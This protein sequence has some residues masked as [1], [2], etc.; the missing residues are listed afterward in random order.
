MY[1]LFIM[2]KNKVFRLAIRRLVVVTVFSIVIIAIGNEAFYLLQKEPHER[3]PQQV[4]LVIPFGTAEMVSRGE[5][6]ASIPEEMV[7]MVGDTLLVK[8][9][10]SVSHQLGPVWIPANASASLSMDNAN[11]YVESCSFQPSQYLGLDVRTPITLSTRLQALVVAGPATITFLFI[12]SILVFPLEKK[13]RSFRNPQLPEYIRF[14]KDHEA[15]ED[16]AGKST[17]TGDV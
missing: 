8:N 15:G 1:G 14:R 11:R 6:V 13:K 5:A 12:Y 9:E 16:S 17:G 4:E 2:T 3:A 10:D 7:F